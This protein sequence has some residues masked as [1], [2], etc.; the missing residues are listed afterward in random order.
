METIGNGWKTI[1]ARLENVKSG[2][3]IDD[4]GESINDSE[5]VLSKFGIR[6]RDTAGEFRSM[7]TVL[8]EIGNRWSEFSSVEQAQIS[9]AIAGT[10][11]R[12]TVIATME[13]YNK[14]LKYTTE[15]A[16][17]AGAAE[18][19]YTD[20]L[21]SIDAKVSTL[22][23][24]WESF[25]ANLN[26]D[27]VYKGVL[28]FLT[29][30]V[31][32]LDTL[33]N[34][35]HA[36][37]GFLAVGG[38]AGLFQGGKKIGEFADLFKK[39]QSVGKGDGLGET[40]NALI[41]LREEKELLKE[42]FEKDSSIQDAL[43]QIGVKT[44]GLSG[45]LL[46]LSLVNKGLSK[47]QAKV[48]LMTKGYTDLQAELATTTGIL[49]ASLAK[50]G[51]Q[52]LTL[53]EGFNAI[54]KNNKFGIIAVGIGAV[55][56]MLVAVYKHYQKVREEAVQAAEDISNSQANLV[57][58]VNGNVDSLVELE[59][60]YKKLSAGV[61]SYGNNV[62]L[63]A[64][65]YSRYQELVNQVLTLS[66]SLVDAYEDE[67][68][69]LRDKTELINAAIEAERARLELESRRNTTGT[70]G[71]EWLE[72]INEESKK[73]RSSKTVIAGLP[74]INDLEQGDSSKNKELATALLKG[75]G[76]DSKTIEETLSANMHGGFLNL[77]KLISDNVDL[78]ANNVS[79]IN[80]YIDSNAFNLSDNIDWEEVTDGLSNFSGDYESA[81]L[82]LDG[83]N[84]KFSEDFL[85]SWSKGLKG[86]SDLTAEEMGVVNRYLQNNI[87]L[88]DILDPKGNIDQGK[89]EGKYRTVGE[90]LVNALNATIEN[91]SDSVGDAISKM[92]TR[93][94]NSIS[95][96]DY[97]A[98][99]NKELNKIFNAVKAT[100][101][102]DLAR[103]IVADV[104]VQYNIKSD[105]EIDA[106]VDAV[107]AKLSEREVY[108]DVSGLS[109][110][111][112]QYVAN[113][114]DDVAFSL[115]MFADGAD[116]TS[117]SV[118]QLQSVLEM[119][120]INFET[121][122]ANAQTLFENLNNTVDAV[123]MLNDAS[124]EYNSTG[125]LSISTISQ[126]LELDDKYLASLQLV[127]GQLVVNTEAIKQ[128]ALANL[129][130]GEAE[131]KVALAEVLRQQ[132]GMVL[133]E[134]YRAN[135]EAS[136]NLKNQLDKEKAAH[137][138]NADQMLAEADAALQLALAKAAE[139]DVDLSGLKDTD[140]WKESEEQY[141]ALKNQLLLIQTAGQNFG[142]SFA[143]AGNAAAQSAKDT[144]DAWKEEFESLYKELQYLRDMDYISEKEYFVRL[145]ALNQKYFADKEQYLDDYRKYAKEVYQGLK[146][147]REQEEKDRLQEKIDDVDDRIDALRKEKEALQ[148]RNEAEDL[149]IKLQKAKDRYNAAKGQLTNRVY[150]NSVG[151][152]WQA[153][154]TE[155]NDAREEVED[156]EK[157]MAR[158]EEEARIDKQIEALEELKQKYQDAMNDI[159]KDIDRH[160]DDIDDMVESELPALDKIG[161]ANISYA[162]VVGAVTPEIGNYLSIQQTQVGSLASSWESAASRIE[163]AAERIVEAAARAAA[164]EK[165]MNRGGGGKS[166]L[167]TAAKTAIGIGVGAAKKTAKKGRAGGIEMGAVDFTGELMVHGSPENPEYILTSN[168]ME[169]FVKNMS[170]SIP[171]GQIQNNNENNN[172]ESVVFQ[173]CTFP[174][175]NVREPQSF[176]P[177]LKQ[178]AKQN[179]K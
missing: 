60:E 177:S 74:L 115:E 55:V 27:G 114:I 80:Q 107:Q 76:L 117:I 149:A 23:A 73:T 92:A 3:T 110:E 87:Q 162:G 66:P 53:A 81:L 35:W 8:D 143:T 88:E 29:S 172:D 126:L 47:E 21:D 121:V 137:S 19:K 141:K 133:H 147:L 90:Q 32:V 98:E 38:V 113:N 9:T 77:S 12:N 58:Q 54:W 65:E 7:E 150:E 22:T 134:V 51:Q 120:N 18:R 70:A 154:E 153:D 171:I 42:A 146:K 28:E 157:E 174:L 100:A 16:N 148:E 175:N 131:T 64:D 108:V 101:G 111:Q 161:Q 164:A 34:E 102:E 56:S 2:K 142:N 136:A 159:G 44:Q 119:M 105:S 39:F 156:I 166:S 163:A 124:A 167:G 68:G 82:T 46:E 10:Y 128:E 57:K 86:A 158:K 95:A 20:Y 123:G 40:V 129:T 179:R 91:S 168:Q 52:S 72:G 125:D 103:D 26:A 176:I 178:I 145:N 139:Q 132:T 144:T 48:I 71:K 78:I 24:T 160:M 152:T 59:D 104:R 61:D 6:L 97:T 45:A 127:N 151:W 49:G 15:S 33:V 50:A 130:A 25:I 62:S 85:T 112:L 96:D 116:G 84:A 14:V 31:N 109:V 4:L 89:L 5:K 169:N 36:L 13:N 93:S 170:R 30:L 69:K 75:A 118:E 138:D 155:V 122:K 106:L 63:T 165:R 41:E 140:A 17:S 1:F 11:Q 135:H 43:T 173:N 79:N 83:T 94:F 37:E 67:N 99:V